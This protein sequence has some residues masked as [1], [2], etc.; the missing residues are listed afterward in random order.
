V[1]CSL[2]VRVP[3]SPRKGAVTAAYATVDKV[4][5]SAGKIANFSINEICATGV[6][7]TCPGVGGTSSA[8]LSSVG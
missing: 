2:K 8:M 1:T 4:N 6:E 5:S 7:T 3:V